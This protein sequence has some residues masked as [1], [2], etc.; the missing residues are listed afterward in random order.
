MAKKRGFSGP[1][2]A[3]V[4][5]VAPYAIGK[6][7]SMIGKAGAKAAD[8]RRIRKGSDV[9]PRLGSTDYPPPRA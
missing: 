1:A 3:I 7:V 5:L 4:G 8:K 9:G 2:G 6:I